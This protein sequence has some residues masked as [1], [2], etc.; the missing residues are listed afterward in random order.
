MGKQTE[1]IFIRH[2]ETEFN[3]ANLFFG[4]MD[5]GLN[6]TGKKQ[7]GTGNE[8]PVYIE[9]TLDLFI[10]EGLGRMNSSSRRKGGLS[11]CFLTQRRSKIVGTNFAT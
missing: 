11:P 10:H 4:H 7:V 5:P 2:G 8:K 1:I 9:E 3:K 6:E